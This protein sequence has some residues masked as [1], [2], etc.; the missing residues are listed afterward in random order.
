MGIAGKAGARFGLAAGANAVPILGQVASIGLTLWGL[1]DVG[2]GIWDILHNQEQEQEDEPIS[3]VE[4]MAAGNYY[5]ALNSNMTN[6]F[7]NN[8][9]PAKSVMDE[10]TN[11]QDLLL[12]SAYI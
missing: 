1:Y 12:K 10:L 3:P 2:K 9:Q 7:Y 6:N 8:P 11:A 4:N 5:R